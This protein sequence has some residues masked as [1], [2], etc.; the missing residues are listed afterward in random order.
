M[1]APV[2]A[3]H[4]LAE[5]LVLEPEHL[6]VVARM[7]PLLRKIVGTGLT[8]EV[9]YNHNTKGYT[10]SLAQRQRIDLE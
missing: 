4:R 9:R 6:A 2:S 1:A 5:K 7:E 10:L 3:A 8:I